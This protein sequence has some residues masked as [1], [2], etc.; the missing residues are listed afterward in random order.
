MVGCFSGRANV[1]QVYALPR[2]QSRE[3]ELGAACS[4]TCAPVP[5]PRRHRRPV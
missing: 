5:R 4:A 2:S 1:E 3:A